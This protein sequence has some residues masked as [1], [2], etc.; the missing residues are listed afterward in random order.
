MHGFL[1]DVR[2]TIR[3]MRNTPGA[4][5]VAVL[6]L[7]LGIGANTAIFS[8]VNALM[9]RPVDLP[10]LNQLVAVTE[11]ELH[12]VGPWNELSPANYL[13]YKA[14]S[15]SFERFAV[16]RGAQFNLSTGGPADHALGGRVSRE[17][18]DVLGAA[19]V[20]GRYFNDDEAGPSGSGRAAVISHRYWRSRFAGD[21]AIVGRTIRIDGA[22]H[23]VVGVA[24][25]NVTFPDRADLWTPLIFTPED[26]N[27][28]MYFAL[29]GVARL[30]HG[31]SPEQADAE[32]NAIAKHLQREHPETNTGRGAKVTPLPR[33]LTGP[34]RE[35]LLLQVGAVAFVLLIACANVANLKLAQVAGRQKELAMRYAL[36]ATGWRVARQLLIENGVLAVFATVAGVLFGVWGVEAIKLGMPA[37]IARFVPGWDH[38]GVDWRTLIFTAA[39]G[40]AAALLTTVIPAAR[41]MSADLQGRLREVSTGRRSRLRQAL[42][43]S[44]VT[45]AVVLLAGAALMG[46]GFWNMIGAGEQHGPKSLLV[47]RT[48]GPDDAARGTRLQRD[49][50]DR[51][52]ALPGV[53]A[54]SGT[55]E[56]PY[57]GTS[58]D[59]PFAIEGE[60]PVTPSELPVA[61]THATMPGYFATM[62][63]PIVRG[64]ALDE[65][66]TE[67]ALRTVVISHSF[68]KQYF[69]NRDPIGMKL[70]IDG[71]S[72][73]VVGIAADVLHHWFDDR[74]MLPTMYRSHLQYPSRDIYFVVRASGEPTALVAPIRAQLQALDP[75]VA[76]LH[77]EG[78]DVLIY[79]HFT[80]VRFGAQLMSVSGLLALVLAAM[81]I[82]AVLSY[83]VAERVQEIGVRIALGATAADVRRAIIN[84]TFALVGAGTLAG[85]IGAVGL[86]RLLSFLIHGISTS[87]V[88]PYLWST[89]LFLAVSLAAAFVP[90]RRAMRV[91]PIVALRQL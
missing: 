4:S 71:R 88:A 21:L 81:G 2:H 49:L 25:P 68:A 58:S 46:K 20:A 33:Y 29:I 38:L 28:R 15:T 10:E 18:F 60:P 63:I 78:M 77:P 59:V 75:N 40:A 53:V 76:M 31:V 56:L 8:V 9:L 30:R 17:Y 13:D 24:S 54:V 11:T 87:D 61:R 65:R 34:A 69:R 14:Q 26:R 27:R 5:I 1:Q 7:G 50:R 72:W 57:S 41:S 55:S 64:R 37:R 48:F 32:L 23:T 70:Q 22:E 82:Y 35:H 52:A 39:V 3:V 66:D 42:V 67:D 36:G 47:F 62:R 86:A 16:V 80:A 84:R 51:I 73:T 85:V 89:L 19:P 79:D 91:D 83:I 74:E 44:E 6:V 12:Q 45:L 43:A 90:A